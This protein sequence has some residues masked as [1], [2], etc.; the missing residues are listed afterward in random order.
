MTDKVQEARNEI[1]GLMATGIGE[2]MGMMLI[3]NSS[4]MVRQALMDMIQ[5]VQASVLSRLS[6]NDTNFDYKK[7]CKDS[8]KEFGRVMLKAHDSGH[9]ELSKEVH[10]V[11]KDMVEGEDNPE[12]TKAAQEAIAGKVREQMFGIQGVKLH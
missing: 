5:T 9:I 6:L 2:V 1:Y 12:N 8:D 10:A 3:S 4:V 11:I 7:Y